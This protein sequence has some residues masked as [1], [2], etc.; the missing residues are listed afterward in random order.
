[1][2]MHFPVKVLS[3]VIKVNLLLVREKGE[4]LCL[5]FRQIEVDKVLFL[6]LLL[7]CL[8]LK[9]T[10]MTKKHILGWYIPTV[11]LEDIT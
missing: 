5:T 3:P 6:H 10:F 4:H 8:Q 11:I 9:I 1:M 2:Q 7:N